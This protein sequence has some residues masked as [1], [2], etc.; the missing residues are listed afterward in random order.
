MNAYINKL[1]TKYLTCSLGYG[2]SYIS[3]VGL[4]EEEISQLIQSKI[5]YL[6]KSEYQCSECYHVATIKPNIWKHIEAKHIGPR[7]VSCEN[8]G[9]VCPSKNAL[10]SHVSR[11]HRK[12]KY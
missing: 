3:A 1:Y 2:Y 7:P 8:C 11:H 4:S 6:G 5:I 9:K 12:E 10:Q